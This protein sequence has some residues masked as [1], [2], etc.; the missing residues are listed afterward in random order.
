M[1][2][3]LRTLILG[4]KELK[5]RFNTLL[6]GLGFAF[7]LFSLA[8]ILFFIF[9][10]NEFDSFS[11]LEISKAF[12]IGIWFDVVPVFYYNLL[13]IILLVIPV[14][15]F[16]N[17][18]FRIS[19]SVIFL[20]TNGIALLQ[21]LI[22]IGYF[23]FNKKRTGA[24]IFHL[25]KEWNKDQLVQYGI[26]FWYL[27][28]IFVVLIAFFFYLIN[29]FSNKHFTT[30]SNS[31]LIKTKIGHHLLFS[32]SVIAITL[33]GLRGGFGLIPLR[34]FDAG[35]F[36][37]S[38]L[39]PLTINTPFQL[40]CTIE[41][42][43][44][45]EFQ[46]MT[47]KEAE[48]IIQ[49]IKNVTDTNFTKKNIVIIIVESLGK[50][51]IGFYNKG[52]GYTPFIDSLCS[53]SLTYNYS[54][55][56]GTT[57]MDA[58]PAIFSGIPNIMNDSYI[59]S[60]FNINNP[61]SIGSILSKKGY[62][63]SFYHGGKNGTMG[64]DNFISQSGMGQYFGLN[65]YPKKEDFDGKWGIF[66]EPYLH[67]FADELNHKTQP[68]ISSV[69]TLSSH[70]PYTVPAKYSTL[71]PKGSLPIHQSVGYTDM[72]L[73]KFFANAEKQ[74]WFSNTLFF[75]TADHTSD[76][77]NPEYQTLLGRY[78][79]PFIV[80]DPQNDKQKIDSTHVMQHASMPATILKLLNFNEPFFSLNN[81]ATDAHSFAVFYSNG[82]YHLVE[83][84]WL[85][86]MSQDG[87][88]SLFDWK[89]DSQMRTNLASENK[90]TAES[91][92]LKLQAYLQTSI[93]RFKD[94]TFGKVEK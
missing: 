55:A 14:Y 30:Q 50:E 92:K 85:L 4:M 94:N 48:S 1:N 2:F 47:D 61:E 72:A 80:F 32:I 79:I 5:I 31:V 11:F 10:Y 49:P 65:E 8:R 86:T 84:N 29:K 63:S 22:D 71:L 34:T 73:K 26:D 27:G 91:L 67:Y 23:P 82:F 25:S 58:P 28:V 76:S 62:N 66:D 7:L 6:L 51:Y 88:Y 21:N 20:I 70:H 16:E 54:F 40:I 3:E 37:A 83:D 13:F 38:G 81:T 46:F 56:N 78:S 15:L 69:F 12:L 77:E 35:R 39:V 59:I 42:N 93:N 19:L 43:N 41:G 17:K 89:H 36:I 60:Q 75:L 24:E 52:K 87:E 90:Q 18:Y 53:K 68:F 33:L 74:P 44:A 9:N 45:P 57:S 64:F